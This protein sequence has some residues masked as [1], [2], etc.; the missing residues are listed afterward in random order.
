[1]EDLARLLGFSRAVCVGASGTA[2]GS[3]L[4][5][6][7]NIDL[8]VNYYEDGFFDATVWDYQTQLH[9]KFYAVYGKPYACDKENFWKSMEAE[10]NHCQLPWALV[11]D[12]NCIRSQEEKLG[13]RKVSYAD[14]KLLRNFM[15]NTGGIDVQFI[16]SKFTWQNKRFKGDLIRERLD[17]AICSPD[18]LLNYSA[19]GT[20]N[21]P[22]TLSDHG[23]IILDTH[24]FA[25]RGYIP[26]R[27]FE[28]WSWEASCKNE[29]INAWSSSG[30]TDTATI[31]FTRNICWALQAWRKKHQG[32]NENE[33]KEL[34]KKLEWIQNQP[35]SDALKDEELKTQSLLSVAWAKSESMWRQKSRE[36]WLSL[37]D[38]NTKFFHAATVLRKRRNSIWAVKDKEGNIWR[39]KKQIA[40]TINSH[41]LDLYS[42]MQ[43]C[44]P[45]GLEDLFDHKI[46]SSANDDLS[47]VP[48]NEEIRE[49]VF[50][51]HPLKAPG[52]DSFSGCFYRKYWDVVGLNLCATVKEFFSSGVMDSKLNSSFICLIP[53]VEFPLSMDQFRPIS[54]C[55]FTYKIIAKILSN[56]LRPL[57]NDLVSPFQSAFIP[58]RWIAE[59]SI[60]TQEI[61]HKIRHKKGFGGLM[62][63]KLDMHKAYDKMEWSFL[64]KVLSANGFSD[65]SR[66]LVMSCVSSVSY[67]VLLNGCPLK[68]FMPQRG[69]RQGDPLSPFLFLLCQE[70]LLK[71]ILKAEA[72]GLIHGIKIGRSTPQVSHLMFVDDTILFARANERDAKTLIDCLTTYEK[73]SGQSCSKHKSSVFF[74]RKKDEY[75]RL[76]ESMLKRLEGWKMKLLSYAGRLTL[77]KS[78]ASAIPIYAMSTNK[79]PISSCHELDSL[80]RK[81]RWL[82]NV[83]KSRFLALKAWDQICQ[84]KMSGGLGLR[85]CTEM[86]KVLLS[87]LAWSLATKEDRPWVSCL[88]NKYCRFESFWCVNQKSS[89]SSQWKC[90]LEARDTILKGSMSVAASGESINFWRQPWIPWLEYQEF[91]ELMNSLRN[92]GYTVQTLADVSSNHCWNEELILQIFGNELGSQIL[93]IPRIPSPYEDQV[94]WKGNQK[95]SFSVKGAY[96]VDNSWRF[97]P[98]R[99]IWKW[100]W[101]ARIHPR[102]SV[103]L[104]RVLNEAIPTKNR[105]HFI[106][107]KSCGLCG[108]EEEDTLHVFCKCRFSKAIC[109]GTIC[110]LRT[111]PQILSLLL[112]KSESNLREFQFLN[113]SNGGSTGDTYTPAV[114]LELIG[115]NTPSN[116]VCHAFFTDASWVRR[117]TGVA[118]IAVDY[119]TGAWFVKALK[120]ETA[121]ALE[122]EFKAIHLA[123]TWAMELGWHEVLVLSDAKVAVQ[124][125]IT[126]SRSPDWKASNIFF[127]IV[128]VLKTLSV[129]RFSFINRSLNALADGIAKNAR[130]ASDLA[131]LYQG[132][133]LSVPRN[134]AM[135]TLNGTNHKQW[136]ESLMLN[137]TFMKVDLALRMDA[138]PEPADDATEK[139]KK[140]YEDWEHSNHLFLKL[141][142]AKD[143]LVVIKE[144][145]KKFSKNEKN[146]CLTLFHCT[147]Y[148][149]TGDIRAHIDKLMGCYQKLKGMGLDLGE[150]Y[151]VWFVMEAIHSQFD[152]IRSSYNAQKEQWTIKEMAAILAKE[153]EDMKKGRARSIS[154]VTNP[155]NSHKRKFTPNNSS[156]QRFHKKKATN[157]KGNGQASSSSTGHKN[158]F[159]NA[160]GIR[161][162]I[163]ESS[164]LI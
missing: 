120:C 46:S 60:L 125:L 43:P 32:A 47:K 121:S 8:V 84:P 57:M 119:T 156:D 80:M 81:F 28:A 55:N 13:G 77:I 6:N 62:A 45:E 115:I 37:G 41:F 91:M 162:L 97:A 117:S 48:S 40:S 108:E 153:E 107:D 70:V 102:I 39:E 93:N 146:E 51:L 122:A 148:A 64:G 135:L 110:A 11:G 71:L 145:Y 18:W 14:T 50:C 52:P 144:K 20:Q 86:N 95:G 38:R 109:K 73:W 138:P 10:F 124:S 26:F 143:F 159:V 74:S 157:P 151:M 30:I 123:L 126:R 101:K 2:G 96:S 104:W 25:S 35:I 78:V 9:W 99:E 94:F 129:V 63:L 76:K 118:A 3:C 142:N 36:I 33:I 75:V 100:I 12:L 141:K 134:S 7:S 140:S 24:L 4:L 58:G 158:E 16:G 15:N 164:K 21:M 29:I 155:N 87:K 111:L 130:V 88:L 5:W 66:K 98:V 149:D 131:I 1:M 137:L 42:S 34:E 54:L 116:R 67:S 114:S 22:V 53:K 23:P 136:V 154:M 79:I 160:S 85:K 128:N 83:E 105:L 19:A 132:E 113:R 152:S 65:K 49:A 90:I 61:I 69:L 17:R 106:N 139:D 112:I 92:R 59:S 27:F 72:Q 103:M 82:G 127:S 163:A 31:A 161:K 68:K 147:N 89:D 133:A 44:T 56:R 150:D